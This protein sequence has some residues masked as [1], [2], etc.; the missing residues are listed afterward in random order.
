MNFRV[1]I[2]DENGTIQKIAIN[3]KFLIDLSERLRRDGVTAVHTSD[4]KGKLTTYHAQAIIMMA[5]DCKGGLMFFP[6]IKE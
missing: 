5:K 2:V 6:D 1:G 4:D 3:N